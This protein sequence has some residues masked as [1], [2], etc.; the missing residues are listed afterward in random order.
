MIAQVGNTMKLSKKN[1]RKLVTTIIFFLSYWIRKVHA[2]LSKGIKS[3][4]LWLFMFPFIKLNMLSFSCKHE[5]KSI[6]R[7]A[8]SKQYPLTKVKLKPRFWFLDYTGFVWE[9]HGLVL[10]LLQAL[11]AFY[12]CGSHVP[13]C[14]W[15]LAVLYQCFY[16]TTLQCVSQNV[17]QTVSEVC[18]KFL[19]FATNLA[20]SLC[21]CQ[22]NRELVLY[23]ELC[24]QVNI[25]IARKFPFTL[26]LRQLGIT[27]FK[28]GYKTLQLNFPRCHPTPA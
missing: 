4:H 15:L 21:S 2:S 3:S 6:E 10:F 18:L 26:W 24:W 5:K 9:P 12:P 8:I 13:M 20:I 14:I 28:M 17:W 1:L 16:S 25:F 27:V 7:K 19:K 23:A 11:C 22:S